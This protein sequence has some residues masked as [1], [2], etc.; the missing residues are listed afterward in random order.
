MDALAVPLLAPYYS[1]H[2]TRTSSVCLGLCPVA[3]SIHVASYTRSSWRVTAGRVP[4]RFRTTRSK[5][6][7]SVVGGIS[8]E[9]KNKKTYISGVV[10]NCFYQLVILSLKYNYVLYTKKKTYL[11]D[12]G[13][14]HS[15]V[16]AAARAGGEGCAMGGRSVGLRAWGKTR[17]G[18]MGP[19]R[20]GSGARDACWERARNASKSKGCRIHAPKKEK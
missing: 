8:L 4:I 5:K 13:R 16:G 9:I 10:I 12:M 20:S 1:P 14:G 6:E 15:N 3:I 19:S 11:L 7:W 2:P 18:G 17:G